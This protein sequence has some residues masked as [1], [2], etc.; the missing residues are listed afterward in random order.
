R[1]GSNNVVS[2]FLVNGRWA[3]PG[4]R[5]PDELWLY[6]PQ[7][8]VRGGAAPFLAR[9]LDRTEVDPDPDVASADVIYRNRLE[10]ATG[11]GVA[12]AWDQAGAGGRAVEVRTEILPLHEVPIVRAREGA[13]DALDMDRL[14]EIPD[15][16]GASLL[17]EPLLAE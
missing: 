2:V 6:Q 1:L 10:F 16:S 5:P 11:H 12:A 3:P 8:R 9:R 13:G 15:G 17:L 14:A 4:R 7:L